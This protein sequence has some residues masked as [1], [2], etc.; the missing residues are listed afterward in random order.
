MLRGCVA[1]QV[2]VAPVNSVFALLFVRRHVASTRDLQHPPG[3]Y[4]GDTMATLHTDPEGA[5]RIVN[6]ALS[7]ADQRA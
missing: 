7:L 6:A 4:G 2:C 1:A 3:R 5:V